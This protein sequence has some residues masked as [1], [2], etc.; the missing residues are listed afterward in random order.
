MNILLLVSYIPGENSC[1]KII[2]KNIF[3]F[4]NLASVAPRIFPSTEVKV[5]LGVDRLD[6]TKGIKSRRG[7]GRY[8]PPPP[9]SFIFVIYVD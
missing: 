4:V 2:K 6:Y 1:V 9:C 7:G 3:R 8:I 5:I